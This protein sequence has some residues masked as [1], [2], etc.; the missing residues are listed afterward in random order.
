MLF[1]KNSSFFVVFAIVVLRAIKYLQHC[2]DFQILF[3]HTFA[4]SL[5]YKVIKY[6]KT[7]FLHPFDSVFRV[8]FR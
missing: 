2:V 6:E 3:F 1:T 5:I 8:Y 7:V 4:F